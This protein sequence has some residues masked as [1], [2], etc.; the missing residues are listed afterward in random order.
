MAYKCK[1]PNF[2][3]VPTQGGL[4]LDNLNFA[5]MLVGIITLAEMFGTKTTT[6]GL[7]TTFT[8]DN[9]VAIIF[10]FLA[11]LCLGYGL[12]EVRILCSFKMVRTK[13]YKQN[14]NYLKPLFY[15]LLVG[16]VTIPSMMYP[17][18]AQD[19]QPNAYSLVKAGYFL[20]ASVV[21]CLGLM[22]FGWAL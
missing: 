22:S 12:S 6:I 14:Y 2:V 18:V 19:N 13:L 17:S 4:G 15:T 10:A 5:V 8:Y 1:I 21:V 3:D 11:G 16:Q 9:M 20:A 7:A